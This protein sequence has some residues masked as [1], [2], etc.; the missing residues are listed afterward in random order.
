MRVIAPLL[1]LAV[2]QAATAA[3]G[4]TTTTL[5]GGFVDTTGKIGIFNTPGSGV[6]AIEL[7]SGKVVFQSNRVQRPLFVAE[8]RLYALAAVQA[9]AVRGLCFE[10]QPPWQGPRTGFRLIAFDLTESGETV[11]VSKTVALPQ[12]A[13]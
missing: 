7:A 2:S 9:P 6:Q 5:P 4:P 13:S 11:L 8:D 1:L 3:A 12:W 10:W